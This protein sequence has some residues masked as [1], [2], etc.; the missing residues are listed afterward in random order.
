MSDNYFDEQYQTAW[1]TFL[2]RTGVA[3]QLVPADL[4]DRCTTVALGDSVRALRRDASGDPEYTDLCM[5][6]LD[7]WLDQVAPLFHLR[8]AGG[9]NDT[10]EGARRKA[11]SVARRVYFCEFVL[12]HASLAVGRV[13]RGTW[14]LVALSWNREH[15]HDQMTPATLSRQWNRVRL[16]PQVQFLVVAR[17]ILAHLAARVEQ[18]VEDIPPYQSPFLALSDEALEKLAEFR[19]AI[20]KM[21]FDK[22][23]EWA[24]YARRVPRNGTRGEGGNAG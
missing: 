2:E 7:E 9:A 21:K 13:H 14:G 24:A 1:D 15:P 8:G 5:E 20:E 10:G 23:Q 4:R 17:G 6:R 12:A 11:R 22:E 16:D 19:R 3:P 18:S